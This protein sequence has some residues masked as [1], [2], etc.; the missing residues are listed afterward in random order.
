MSEYTP[1]TV[2]VREFYLGQLVKTGDNYFEFVDEDKATA[3]FDRWLAGVKAEAWDEAVSAMQYSDGSP[4]E[5]LE[6]LNPY[7]KETE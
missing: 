2:Q 5:L 3:E 6:N 7:R 4:V 1:T